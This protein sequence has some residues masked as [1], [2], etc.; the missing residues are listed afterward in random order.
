MFLQMKQLPSV[1]NLRNYPAEIIRELEELLRSGGSALPD[2]K[3]KDFYDLENHERTFFIQISSIT[4]RVVLLA[5]WL[6]RERVIEHKGCAKTGMDCT[7]WSPVGHHFTDNPD[8]QKLGGQ[9]QLVDLE[10]FQSEKR[11]LEGV[12]YVVWR[13]AF[14]TAFRCAFTYF[15]HAFRC[16]LAAFLFAFRDWRAY[17]ATPVSWA[18]AGIDHETLKAANNVKTAIRFIRNFLFDFKNGIQ[19]S[20]ITLVSVS[21]RVRTSLHDVLPA[22]SAHIPVKPFLRSWR[23]LLNIWPGGWALNGRTR[24]AFVS[25]RPMPLDFDVKALSSFLYFRSFLLTV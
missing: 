15:F 23:I 10:G 22:V 17:S 3:R 1:D 8:S 11:A 12:R 6:R 20:D 4:G 21:H 25:F 14:L 2:P 19:G 7:T 18:L 5:T 9:L 16:S 24:F 13:F